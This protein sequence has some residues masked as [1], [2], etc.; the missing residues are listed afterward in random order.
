MRGILN[1]RCCPARIVKRAAP[2]AQELCELNYGSAPDII[3]NGHTD[4]VF[5]YIDVHLEYMVFELL[6]NA[7]RATVDYSRK[8]DREKHPPIEVTIGASA[9]DADVTIRIRDR[10]GGISES[11]E[12]HVFDYSYS[13]VNEEEAAVEEAAESIFT[14]TSKLGVVQGTGGPMAGYVAEWWS[15]S[16]TEN[17]A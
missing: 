3:V 5:P 12:R 8:I 9:S 4:T 7:F 15:Y 2:L 11:R 17:G 13:T 1:D 10:G 14:S 16:T 6:K